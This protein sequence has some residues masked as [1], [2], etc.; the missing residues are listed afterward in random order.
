MVEGRVVGMCIDLKYRPEE[1]VG[2]AIIVLMCHGLPLLSVF[3]LVCYIVVLDAQV[4]SN[5]S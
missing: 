4:I 3:S 1:S 5:R 2:R